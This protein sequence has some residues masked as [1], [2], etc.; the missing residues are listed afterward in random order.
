MRRPRESPTAFAMPGRLGRNG[1]PSA[2]SRFWESSKVMKESG[3]MGLPWNTYIWNCHVPVEKDT[4]P[5]DPA[6]VD[7]QQMQSI[8]SK[9]GCMK[10]GYGTWRPVHVWRMSL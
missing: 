6:D 7:D 4:E 9:D 3:L 10:Y 1:V 5:D 2:E 8:P